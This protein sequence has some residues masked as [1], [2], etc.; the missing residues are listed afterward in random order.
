MQVS[1]DSTPRNALLSSMTASAFERLRHKIDTV[2]LRVDE[3]TADIGVIPRFVYF[4]NTAIVSVRRQ[5]ADGCM[6]EVSSIGNEGVTGLPFFLG[7]R[8]THCRSQVST[9]GSAARMTMAD[10]MTASQSDGLLNGALRLYAARMIAEAQRAV[11]CTRF[12]SI[13]Q[14][15][16]RWLLCLADRAGTESVRSTHEAAATFLGV[17]R[18]SITTAV[19]ALKRAHVIDSRRGTMVILDRQR[20]E[21][22]ACVCYRTTAASRG[23]PVA[24]ARV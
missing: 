14:Q 6:M 3:I 20:L 8:N 1:E 22:E 2:D 19:A 16:A 24:S 4:P 23:T 13:P 21:R 9:A 15:F 5:L 10:F 17:R 7:I 12:H 18:A 11:V